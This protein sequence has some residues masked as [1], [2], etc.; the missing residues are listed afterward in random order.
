MKGADAGARSVRCR[1]GRI[2]SAR[3]AGA[4]LTFEV[5][6]RNLQRACLED[7][8]IAALPRRRHVEE[9]V[10][11]VDGNSAPSEAIIRTTHLT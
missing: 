2:E 3:L 6:A 8:S 9:W 10:L 4:S 1:A 5:R 7:T 11:Q